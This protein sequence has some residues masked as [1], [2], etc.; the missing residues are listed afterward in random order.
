MKKC[1]FCKKDFAPKRRTAKYCSP[2]CRVKSYKIKKGE[3]TTFEG[4]KKQAYNEGFADCVEAMER[5]LSKFE[6]KIEI[7]LVDSNTFCLT[8][9]RLR[10]SDGYPS[11]VGASPHP[12][13]S[14]Q[15][16]LGEI[17]QEENNLTKG[18]FWW[19]RILKRFKRFF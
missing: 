17:G 8:I 5:E 4:V 3:V 16:A 6:L 11:P 9:D 12:S 13:E 1:E 19:E 2:A 7:E 14:S 10:S 15:N 18:S